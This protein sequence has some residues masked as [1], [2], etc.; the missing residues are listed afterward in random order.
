MATVAKDTK[1]FTWPSAS[2]VSNYVTQAHH[3]FFYVHVCA[4]LHVS[5][6]L[7]RKIAKVV[8]AV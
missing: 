4:H 1:S 5:G 8:T 3:L 7:H 2:E 6:L